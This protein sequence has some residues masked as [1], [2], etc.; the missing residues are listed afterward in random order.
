MDMSVLCR[1]DALDQV[2]T[3]VFVPRMLRLLMFDGSVRHAA[4][5]EAE[6]PAAA[7]SA[8]E[9]APVELIDPAAMSSALFGPLPAAGQAAV[10]DIG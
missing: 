2:P 7:T 5:A 3:S 1:V 4:R 8:P 6:Q 10:F 9:T